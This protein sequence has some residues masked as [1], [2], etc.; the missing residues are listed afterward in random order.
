MKENISIKKIENNCKIIF[1][2]RKFSYIYSMKIKASIVVMS[3]LSDAQHEMT[4]GDSI[5]TNSE[6]ND[7]INFA[8]YI[9]LQ[10]NGDLNQE[11]DADEMYKNFENR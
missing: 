4:I 1:Q 6:V 8:K 3:H 9:I 5:F 2:Y 7:R 10:C 11:I